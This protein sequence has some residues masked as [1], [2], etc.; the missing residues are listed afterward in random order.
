MDGPRLHDD[1]VRALRALQ[2]PDGGFATSAAGGSELEPTT[3]A[4]LAL[5]NA[6]A[7]EWLRRRQRAD[8]GF[9]EPDGRPGSP[10][11]GALAAL[12]LD[13]VS[14]RHA[15]AF[16]IGERG[17]PLP[18]A[19][20]PGRR[21]AWGWT[22]DAR[23]LVEPTARVLIAVKALAP[24]DAA[25]RAEALA[26]LTERQCADGGWNF[27]NA[28]LY[29]VDL[30]AYAQT[31]AMALIAL[32]NEAGA[33]V[34]PGLEFLRESWAYEPGALTAAQALVA[35]RLH[36]RVGETARLV[37]A[38]AARVLGDS[39]PDTPLVLSWAALATGPDEL[40]DVLRP[41]A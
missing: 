1:L 28:S 21:T 22:S 11:T 16:A 33:V 39:F 15:L 9:D 41:R 19:P 6:A 5:R 3:L 13:T 27:G 10:T 20:D 12:V 24:R 4:A 35:F 36:G 32:Q 2:R 7:V 23:S 29:D 18:N 8:G 30:R 26:L 31:T 37:D 40:L 17:L 38:I 34:E 25:T 14:A